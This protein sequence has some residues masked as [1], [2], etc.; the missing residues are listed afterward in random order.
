MEVQNKDIPV[1]I[2]AGGYGSR[3]GDLVDRIP[4]PMVRI[5]GLPMLVHVIGLWYRAGFREFHV[6][7]GYRVNDMKSDWT[8]N[9]YG[10]RF[11]EASVIIHDTGEE[12]QTAGRLLRASEHIGGRDFCAS[13]GDGLT[14]YPLGN[15][16]LLGDG[17]HVIL[18]TH[19]ISRFGNVIFDDRN[20]VTGFYEKPIESSWISSGFF[21]FKNSIMDEI[22][23]DMQVLETDIFYNLVR[24][25]SMSVDRIGGWWH[26]M[27]TPKD[28]AN[29]CSL[30]DS[31]E[32]PWEK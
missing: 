23:S 16:P 31:G 27:D 30:Y 20:V 21:Y 32:A 3:L 10:S 18:V 11:P 14:D 7:G 26:C 19:P 5:G 29:L 9:N 28:L 13:Y 17:N 15:L 4:K 22:T 1:V 12:T 8:N 2:F 25:G 24:S 6:L